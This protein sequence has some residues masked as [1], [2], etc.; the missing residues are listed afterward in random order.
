MEHWLKVT[1]ADRFVAVPLTISDLERQDVKVVK[2]FRRIS[3]ITHTDYLTY[4]VPW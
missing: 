1:G 2:R 4:N 3:V